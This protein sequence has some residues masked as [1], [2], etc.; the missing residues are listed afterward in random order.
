[1]RFSALNQAHYVLI[2]FLSR[3]KL[4][5]RTLVSRVPIQ[6]RYLRAMFLLF[7]SGGGEKASIFDAVPLV[8]ANHV[9]SGGSDFG[10]V[11]TQV[12]KAVLEDI[13]TMVGL[14]EMLQ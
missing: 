5:W 8:G 1:L 6:E 9:S 3:R 13:Q 2:N 10:L 7:K 11:W 4:L 14:G 12:Q